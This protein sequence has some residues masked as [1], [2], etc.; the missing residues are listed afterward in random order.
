VV[1]L[2]REIIALWRGPGKLSPQEYFYYRLWDPSLPLE[3]K[4]RFV[5]KKA[6]NDMHL[7]CNSR[8]WYAAAADKILFHTIMAGASLPVPDLLAITAAN[9]SIPG[10]PNLSD[11]TALAVL[12]HLPDLDP[13]F[14]KEAGLIREATKGKRGRSICTEIVQPVG[15]CP[16]PHVD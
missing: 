11:A 15:P 3:E 5:G 10:I 4:R 13:L 6:Q 7:A 1:S 2:L 14:M 8:Y 9:R 16:L 12:L